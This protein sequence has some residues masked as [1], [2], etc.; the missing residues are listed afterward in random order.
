MTDQE[1]FKHRLHIEIS[2]EEFPF[3]RVEC[4]NDQIVGYSSE[5][6]HSFQV[7]QMR[8]VCM[9]DSCPSK[10]CV[11][12]WHSGGLMPDSMCDWF[13]HNPY[14]MSVSTNY[15]MSRRATLENMMRTKVIDTVIS[16]KA[17]QVN[18]AGDFIFKPV[19]VFVIGTPEDLSMEAISE[20]WSYLNQ[21]FKHKIINKLHYTEDIPQLQKDLEHVTQSLSSIGFGFIPSLLYKWDD[22]SDEYFQ[23][24]TTMIKELE[25][26]YAVNIITRLVHSK[27]IIHNEV[28][29][30]AHLN[31]SYWA[32]DLAGKMKGQTILCVAGGP[33]L[34]KDIE[35]IKSNR[36]KYTIFCVSTVAEVLFNNDIVPDL[37]ATIDMKNHNKKYLE[38]L[39]G[40]QMKQSILLFEIDAGSEVVDY[41]KGDKMMLVANISENYATSHIL[42]YIKEEKNIPKTGTVSNM[43]YNFACMLEPD[44]IILSGYDL[45]YR[46]TA[47][48]VE[49]ARLMT[50]VQIIDG[51]TGKFIAHSG[52]NSL[53]EAIPLKANDGEIVYASKAF[54]T[55]LTELNALSKKANVK[56]YDLTLEGVK[57]ENID[58]IEFKD[59]K[60]ST[61]SDFR[62]LLDKLEKKKFN[63]KIVKNIIGALSGNAKINEVYSTKLSLMIK[64]YQLHDLMQYNGVIEKF[65]GLIKSEAKELDKYIE[66]SLA[67]FKE[68]N[69]TNS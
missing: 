20:K 35:N 17:L 9:K 12:G 54:K 50:S 22:C 30:L 34:S 7:G 32:Y 26:V 49:G 10:F 66:Q 28:L 59:I 37:I 27:N 69:L 65:F 31:H 55:Y 62:I 61:S 23:M 39:T 36:D 56:T 1:E 57:K 8:N 60:L 19:T 42:S 52:T 18:L 5:C 11:W 33:S 67:R 3:P 51:E 43:I 16:E 48:H 24:C 29:N 45:S 64:Q 25:D 63:N 58:Y 47:S 15:F 6:K 68:L 4:D 40:D 38:H 21:G 53:E 14:W 44:Q 2:K 41:Y 46:G 13:E